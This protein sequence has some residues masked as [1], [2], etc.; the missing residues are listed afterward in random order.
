M[1][2]S[3]GVRAVRRTL[4]LVLCFWIVAAVI[5]ASAAGATEAARRPTEAERIAAMLN[6][7][8]QSGARF[9]RGG[10]EYSGVEGRKHLERKLRHAGNRVRT[11]EEFIEGI[12]SR[13]SITGR[14]Y[15]VRLPDGREMESGQWFRDKLAEIDARGC[16]SGGRSSLPRSVEPR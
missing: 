8:E 7:A 11:A 9:L 10:K 3:E 6:A 15:R 1:R 5:P 13:S 4:V 2:R 16:R 12:A 14:P